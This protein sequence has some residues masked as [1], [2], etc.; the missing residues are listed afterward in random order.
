MDEVKL[1]REG[2]IIEA[3]IEWQMLGNQ[4]VEGGGEKR[5]EGKGC[6]SAYN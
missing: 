2:V 3:E 4:T 1:A 5:C 6:V